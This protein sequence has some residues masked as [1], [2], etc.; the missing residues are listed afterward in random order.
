M[1]KIV[2]TGGSGFIGSCFVKHLNNLGE[3]N[4]FIVDDLK[5]EKE[6]NLSNKKFLDLI[7]KRDVFVFLKKNKDIKSIVHLGACS[8]TL[9][10]D[11]KY[12]LNNNFYFSVSLAKYALKNNIRFIYAS[13]AATYGMGEKGFKED[14]IED[15]RPVNMYAF[16]KQLFD[17]WVK[18]KKILDKIVGLKY[19]NVFG[20]NEYH[21]KHMASM[22]FKMVEKVKRGEKL[23]LYKSNSKKYKDGEQK[24]D[25]IYVKDAV[26][27]SAL[28]LN[29]LKDV[30]GIFN[31]G[32]GAATSWN[33]LAY[34]L[35]K[36]FD[37]E[38][39]I[40]YM[41]MPKNLKKQ[42]QNYTCADMEK[43]KGFYDFKCMSI[44]EAVFDY[45]QNYLLKKKVW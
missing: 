17:V 18:R 16:S 20:P 6:K 41:E 8:D 9:E 1:K 30:N 38:A 11:V 45:V 22:V 3:E 43:F 4:I 14:E 37:K 5:E 25:F 21:K 26:A 27:M 19:F 35:F 32:S 13:S 10:S 31:I 12:L 23:F 39:S 28:F 29:E 40:E 34:F 44:K 24:R 15:L 7:S 36:A 42:Y 2:V 33:D